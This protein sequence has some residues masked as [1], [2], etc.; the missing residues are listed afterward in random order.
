MGYTATQVTG[1]FS[2]AAAARLAALLPIAC[3][4]GDT[5]A[6]VRL[7]VFNLKLGR[8]PPFCVQA[9]RPNQRQACVAQLPHAPEG[10]AMMPA[11]SSLARSPPFLPA[12]ACAAVPVPNCTSTG[13][14]AAEPVRSQLGRPS[15]LGHALSRVGCARRQMPAQTTVLTHRLLLHASGG[16]LALDRLALDSAL[17]PAGRHQ[18]QRSQ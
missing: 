16:L 3:G 2:L 5:A 13:K 7:A 9:S 18:G 10:S 14:E 11:P 15:F 1:S 8:L 17:L 4:Q 6:R 12:S